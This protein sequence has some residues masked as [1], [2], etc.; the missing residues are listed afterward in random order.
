MKEKLR[1]VIE[2]NMWLSQKQ[3]RIH[4]ISQEIIHAR[5]EAQKMQM[6]AMLASEKER[7]YPQKG[8]AEPFKEI[9]GEHAKDPVISF[10][11]AKKPS[12]KRNTETGQALT[13]GNAGSAAEKISPVFHKTESNEIKME[14]G[15]ISDHK[16]IFMD[17]QGNAIKVEANEGGLHYCKARLNKYFCG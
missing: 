16:D 3:E 17:E 6:I 8:G 5:I 4:E 15:E 12:P 10:N 13:A 1:H 2:K 11:F 14:N 7:I 9:L